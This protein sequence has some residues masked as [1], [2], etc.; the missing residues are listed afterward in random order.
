MR[1]P[2]TINSEPVKR[3]A[4]QIPVTGVSSHRWLKTDSAQLREELVG[5]NDGRGPYGCIVARITMLPCRPKDL[6]K[7]DYLTSFVYPRHTRTHMHTHTQKERQSSLAPAM[8][9]Y[10]AGV[11]EVVRGSLLCRNRCDAMRGRSEE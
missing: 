7:S 4:N 11:A 2:T 1:C 9:S 3:T 6:T 10:I 5:C 8:T